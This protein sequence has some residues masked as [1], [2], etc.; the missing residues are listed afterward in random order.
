MTW[1]ALHEGAQNRIDSQILICLLNALS[2]AALYLVIL[3]NLRY[4][5]I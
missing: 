4:L 3:A 1:K 5:N 2:T